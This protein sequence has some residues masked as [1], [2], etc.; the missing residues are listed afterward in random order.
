MRGWVTDMGG[1]AMMEIQVS[2]HTICIDG[3][4]EE[5]IPLNS[6]VHMSLSPSTINVCI[7]L[8]EMERQ[9]QQRETSRSRPDNKKISIYRECRCL[10]RAFGDIPRAGIISDHEYFLMRFGAISSYTEL[11]IIWS[12][13]PDP[14]GTRPGAANHSPHQHPRRT[15]SE[16]CLH[17]GRPEQLHNAG[18]VHRDLN[19]GNVMWDIAQAPL[20]NVNTE[21]KYKLLGRPKKIALPSI[22]WKPGEL[23]KPL[24]VPMS[25]PRET[26]Y[27]GDFGMAIKAGH[28]VEH[29]V[30]WP[31]IYCGPERFHNAKPSFSSAMWMYMVLFVQF[32]LGSAPWHCDNCVSLMNYM[33]R[34]V[35][36]LPKEWKGQYN[37]FELCNDSW[38]DQ[39]NEPSIIK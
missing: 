33:V 23:V 14:T 5:G 17:R 25:L 24:E 29:K 4:L 11:E 36:P 30:L 32:Y 15:A 3:F 27:L 26:V 2:G 10:V 7:Y 38:Y 1:S 8:E 12:S 6:N 35:G 31:I 22:L 19:D 16:R 28:E 20:G 37:A 18:I 21:T 13:P 9:Q 34:V 39:D